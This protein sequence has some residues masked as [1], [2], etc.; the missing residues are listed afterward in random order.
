MGEPFGK[1]QGIQE[2]LGELILVDCSRNI[3]IWGYLL[4]D[5]WRYFLELLLFLKDV[6]DL[7]LERA[8]HFLWRGVGLGEQGI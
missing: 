8:E 5:D 6:I 4:K 2:H 1:N 3:G 7:L